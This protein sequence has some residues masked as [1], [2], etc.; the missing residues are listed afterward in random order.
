MNCLD[1]KTKDWNPEILKYAENF[2]PNL[3]EKLDSP[4]P[5]ADLT[6][7]LSW[8]WVDRFGMSKECRSRSRKQFL[9]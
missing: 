7:Y 1:I 2:A 8:Y 4:A 5:S 3:A 6:G 9:I